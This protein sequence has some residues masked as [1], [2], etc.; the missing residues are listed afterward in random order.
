MA[1]VSEFNR[2][3]LLAVCHSSMLIYAWIFSTSATLSLYFLT[4]SL[5]CPRSMPLIALVNDVQLA[6]FSGILSHSTSGRLSHSVNSP[7]V[8]IVSIFACFARS[9]IFSAKATWV[10]TSSPQYFSVIPRSSGL[11]LIST[12]SLSSSILLFFIFST[13]GN[14]CLKFCSRF[15]YLSFGVFAS[16]NHSSAGDSDF[17]HSPIALILWSSVGVTPELMKL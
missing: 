1:F 4:P 16:L 14:H 6:W 17:S 12:S 5:M 15:V 10:Y 11:I 13:F 9:I 2:A 8:V 3:V 7:K